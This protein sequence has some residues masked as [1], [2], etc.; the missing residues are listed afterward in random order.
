MSDDRDELELEALRRELEDAF[1]TTRPRR[2]FEDELWMRLQA[3]RPWPARVRDAFGGL[4]AALREVPAVPAAAVAAVLVIAIGVGVIAIG[5]LHPG[6]TYSQAGGSKSEVPAPADHAYQGLLPT[7]VL[8]PGFADAGI[9]GG[10]STA[11]NGVANPAAL[12]P[13]NLYFGPAKLTWAG[14]FDVADVRAP[15]YSYREPSLAQAD[16]FAAAVGASG[17]KQVRQV[18]GFLGTYSGQDFTVSVRGTV[19]QLPREPYFLLTPSA[20]VDGDILGRYS[21]VP[22][23]NYLVVQ[24]ESSTVYQRYVTL[25]GGAHALFVNWIGDPDGIQVD[26]QGG[27]A[28]RAFGQLPLTLAPTSYPLISNQAA[29]TA[30]L[31]S[32]ASGTSVISPEPQ[33]VLDH[34]QLVYALAV[35]GGQGYFEPAYLFSGSFTYNGQT[36]VKRVL[37]PL[38]QPSLRQS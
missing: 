6:G 1:E 37:V 22:S 10:Q 12:P 16:Q 36:Y 20:P 38:V 17:N 31:A 18:N 27:K 26:T 3:R 14:T 33:V 32:G 9:P 29:V 34:V 11:P 13:S 4:V 2:G 24:N 19:P 30:A 25:D 5:S 21:L 23:W 28:V 15:V 8:H 35:A 7:P